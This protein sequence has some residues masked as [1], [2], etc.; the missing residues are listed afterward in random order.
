MSKLVPELF[1]T[2]HLVSGLRELDWC[3]A[4]VA[5]KLT[6]GLVDTPSVDFGN[7]KYPIACEIIAYALS[8]SFCSLEN[9]FHMNVLI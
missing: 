8:F 6:I 1:D 9:L 7:P 2:L 4:T 5:A 3:H